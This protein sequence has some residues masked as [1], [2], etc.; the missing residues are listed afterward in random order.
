M[1]L[2]EVNVEIRRQ[3][4][5]DFDRNNRPCALELAAFATSTEFMGFEDPRVA[6]MEALDR[7]ECGYS[8]GWQPNYACQRPDC[9]VVVELA[10][11]YESYSI[12]SGA[13]AMADL[14]I[15]EQWDQ[16]RDGVAI[17][18]RLMDQAIGRSDQYNAA[19]LCPHLGCT[20]NCGFSIDGNS[21]TGGNCM[22][23]GEES[24]PGV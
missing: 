6:A 20:F 17:F 18:H 14:C 15:K 8:V 1:S 22:R 5:H 3:I 23:D 2:S 12:A 10:R 21:G 9:D 7:D 24:A 4:K 13:C 16:R 19:H 11:G